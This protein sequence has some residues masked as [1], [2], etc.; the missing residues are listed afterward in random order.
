MAIMIAPPCARAIPVVPSDWVACCCRMAP[1][2]KKTSPKV[3]IASA[4]RLRAPW[5]IPTPLLPFPDPPL[6]QRFDG[7]LVQTLRQLHQQLHRGVIVLAVH[8]R[9]MA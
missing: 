6:L 9:G 7:L 5:I 1:T 3:P 2:P 8:D 4:R